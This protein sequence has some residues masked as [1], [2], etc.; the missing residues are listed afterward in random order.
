MVFT[1]FGIN[2]DRQTNL[3]GL[4]A[5]KGENRHDLTAKKNKALAIK[6]QK[7]F[8]KKFY[9]LYPVKI[10]RFYKKFDKRGRASLFSRPKNL[11]EL[12]KTTPG[13]ILPIIKKSAFAL[14]KQFLSST[15]KRFFKHFVKRRL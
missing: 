5:K 10:A 4:A 2:L 12:S 14:H 8:D 13:F 1:L 15:R 7:L 6:R 9:S 3:H 11:I